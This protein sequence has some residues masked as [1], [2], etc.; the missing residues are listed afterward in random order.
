MKAVCGIAVVAGFLLALTGGLVMAGEDQIV[1]AIVD[2]RLAT[3][4]FPLPGSQIDG[5]SPDKAYQLQKKLAEV[6]AQ[7]GHKVSGFK[8]GL[9]SAPAQKKFG[10]EHPLMG[11]LFANGLYEPGTMVETTSFIRP[12]I[13]TEV[14]YVVGKKIDQPMES[15]DSLK[16]HIQAVAPV[17][18]LPD[19]RFAELKGLTAADLVVDAVASAGYL[20]GR[21]RKPEDVSLDDV[22]VTLQR[23]GETVNEGRAKDALGGQWE[24]LAWL[25]NEAVDR[26]WTIEPGH[27]LITGALGKMIPAKPG[28]YVADFGELGK[29]SFSVK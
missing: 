17:I 23:D 8:G 16:S 10:V 4:P 7:K 20:V 15:A 13:E 24:A 28:S 6:M 1:E 25:V 29:I 3:K 21:S 19:L 11:P 14:G 12:F 18:E 22:T 9:T 27:I 26:G 5:L 2:A